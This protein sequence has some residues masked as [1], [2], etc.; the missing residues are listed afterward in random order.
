VNIVDMALHPA[1]DNASGLIALWIAGDRA[2]SEAERLV[3]GL[4]LPVARS[5]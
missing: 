5:A 4:G 1:P 3:E 2:A